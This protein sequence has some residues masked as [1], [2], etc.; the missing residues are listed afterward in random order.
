MDLKK[1]QAE[2]ETFA[3]E[4]DWEQ[5][6]S[7]KNI[8][9]ALSV[10]CAELVEHF[11][12]LTEDESRTLDPGQL[13]AVSFEMV[14]V[15]N[16]LLRL[17]SVLNVDLEAATEKKMNIN[18][19]HYPAD[20]VRGSAKNIPS[21]TTADSLLIQGGGATSWYRLPL[22]QYFTLLRRY[23]HRWAAVLYYQSATEAG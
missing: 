10:E 11:Q 23:N 12:W 14:D 2:L 13:E 8:A 20:K 5:F 15:L 21:T 3:R 1:H 4:R 6:H 19:Q 9:M 17:S 16:Y 7:P 22:N 18:R